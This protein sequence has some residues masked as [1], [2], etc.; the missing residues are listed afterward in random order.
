MPQQPDFIFLAGNANAPLAQATAKILKMPVHFPVTRF[1][2][3]EAH[4]QIPVNVRHKSVVIFQSTC[5]PHIDQDYIELFLLIDAAR[6]ASAQDII[7][8]I[9]HFGYA[10]QDRKDKP[11]VPISSSL[12]AKLLETAGASRICTLDIH[13]DQ[14][15]GFVQM[16]WDNIYGSFSII[17]VLKKFKFDNLVLASPDKGGVLM[18]TAYAQRMGA[19]GLAIV[20]KDRDVNLKNESKA[21]DL[22]GE[23]KG[24]NVILVDDM[25][26][27]AGTLVHAAELI[28]QRGAKK[29]IAAATHGVFS[30]DALQKIENSPIE[31]VVVT[32]SI[33]LQEPFLK[34]KKIKVVSVAPLLAEAIKRIYSGE[35]ISEK[36]ILRNW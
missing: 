7:V 17:P 24:K 12:I 2:N 31:T 23:V 34:S 11:R 21:M 22:I 10:R 28:K 3:E 13:S 35:S 14:E 30:G 27:T 36:L 6:R 8:I 33:Q 9:P 1:A 4:V 26:D 32:D 20:F 16:P 15:Q 19:E 29:I 5:P 18:A 25:I